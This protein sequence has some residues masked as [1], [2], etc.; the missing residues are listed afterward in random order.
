[1]PSH[2]AWTSF[3]LPGLNINHMCLQPI[4]ILYKNDPEALAICDTLVLITVNE[5]PW[6][7]AQLLP[8]IVDLAGHFFLIENT[9]MNAAIADIPLRCSQ[10]VH[11]PPGNTMHFKYLALIPIH[12]GIQ[13]PLTPQFHR[14]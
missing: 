7:S 10:A 12:L 4:R 5:L 3:S 1:M 14:Q 9:V 13:L 6:H 2:K 8:H 11:S